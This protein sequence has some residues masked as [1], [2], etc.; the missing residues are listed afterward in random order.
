MRRT[1]LFAGALLSAAAADGRV[2]H[3]QSNVFAS[4]TVPLASPSGGGV[5]NLAFG[6][7][8]PAPGVTTTVSV[9]AA[10]APQSASVMSGEFAL[11]VAGSSGIDFTV[12]VPSILTSSIGGLTI[13]VSFA[14]TQYGA[15][16]VVEGGAACTTTAFNPAAGGTFKQC[17]EY[18][19]NGDCKTNR[20]WTAGTLLRVFVGGAV[21][22]APSAVAATYTGTVT[23]S[24]VQVY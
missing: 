22:V 10:A 13:P 11:S 18:K 9:P 5:R 16:C 21:S 1:L 3:A 2:L 19:G 15:S 7:I 4:A 12:S 23:L 8:M 20:V 24:I 17:R 6:E 14:G